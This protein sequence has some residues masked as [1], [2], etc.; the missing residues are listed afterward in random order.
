MPKYRCHKEVSAL[1]IETVLPY[2]GG[3]GLTFE[4][5]QFPIRAFSNDELKNKPTPQSGMYLVR[6]EDG[7]FSFSPAETFESGYTRIGQ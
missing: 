7:Y 3:V 1:K 6:Y 4:D 2:E 5:Q